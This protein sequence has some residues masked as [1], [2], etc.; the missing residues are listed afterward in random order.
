MLLLALVIGTSA[1]AQTFTL[2]YAFTGGADGGDPEGGLIMDSQGNLYGATAV[3]GNPACL[4][5]CGTVFKVN[6]TGKESVLYS[7]A[8]TDGD[9]YF[10]SATLVQNVQGNLYG[11][12]QV[13]LLTG[14]A[15]C[16]R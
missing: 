12:T 9:G 3:G 13:G 6:T 7:F 10:P 8:G 14:T 15:W 2:L 4:H 1:Q 16:S 11:T 5:G